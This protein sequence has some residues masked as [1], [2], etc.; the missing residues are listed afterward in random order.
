MRISGFFYPLPAILEIVID[1]I[2]VSVIMKK[3]PTTFIQTST[4]VVL[5]KQAK[6]LFGTYLLRT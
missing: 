2:K 4:F 1:L 6:K 3:K 5:N